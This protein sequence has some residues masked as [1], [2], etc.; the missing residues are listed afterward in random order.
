MDEIELA[1]GEAFNECRPASDQ[2]RW[3]DLEAGFLEVS[4][5]MSHKQRGGVGDGQVAD[6]HDSIVLRARAIGSEPCRRKK[7]RETTA[8][9]TVERV[10]PRPMGI[11]DVVTATM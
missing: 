3:F 10:T 11:C 4:L 8:C 7:S 6:A 1:R 9:Q 5:G 2:R